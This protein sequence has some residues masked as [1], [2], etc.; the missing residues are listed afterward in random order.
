MVSL[1]VLCQ[2]DIISIS[3]GR[4]IGRADDIEF[5]E[6]TAVVENLVVFG[7]PKFFGLFGRGKDVRIPWTDVI[8]VGADVILIKTRQYDSDTRNGT[9][10]VDYD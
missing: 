1:S 2:K 6:R 3:T 9:V 5:N 7:R 10:H 8:T 4:N